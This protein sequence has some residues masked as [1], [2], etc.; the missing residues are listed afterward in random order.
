MS[1]HPTA[2]PPAEISYEQVAAAAENLEGRGA[3]PTLPRVCEH[4]GGGSPNRIQRHLS[5]WRAGR[6]PAPLP[7]PRLPAALIEALEREIIQHAEAALARGER[8]ADEA[9]ADATSLAEL[10]E[11]LEQRI[12]DQ[13]ARLESAEQAAEQASK[14]R[15]ELQAQLAQLRE[16]LELEQRESRSHREALLQSR[17]QVEMLREQLEEAVQARLAAERLARN[18][19]AE[20]VKAERSQ[21]VAETQRDSA[22]AQVRDK[23]EQYASLQKEMQAERARQRQEVAEMRAEQKARLDSLERAK[24][25]SQK[26]AQESAQ[27]ATKAEIRAEALQATQAALKSRVDALQVQQRQRSTRPQGDREPPASPPRAGS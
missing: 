6:E 9:R 24:Q 22:L 8:L 5:A 11:V 18:A 13:A 20:R 4:L 23:A 14:R 26:Q 3:D 1:R 16:S 10:G 25:E 15:D 17:Q 2:P 12:I 7:E 19:D 21:A 27:R